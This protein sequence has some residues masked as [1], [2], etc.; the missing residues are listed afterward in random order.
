MLKAHAGIVIK[1]A[2]CTECH[3]PHGAEKPKLLLSRV[4]SPFDGGCDS[5]HD[6]PGTAGGV[7]LNSPEPKLCFTCHPDKEEAMKMKVVHKPYGAGKCT[8]CH[9]PHAARERAMLRLPAV[10][11]CKDCHPGVPDI[12][13]PV[14][15]HPAFK[16]GVLNPRD[17]A[18][19]FYC[20][21]CHDPHAGEKSGL[22]DETGMVFCQ[23]CHN[24][25]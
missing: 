11:L 20:A 5:C 9:S 8:R 12:N 3:D 24:Q 2:K 25:Q 17:T 15:R 14:Q 16:N 21:S 19:P 23:K 22:R 1:D 10:A 4:H 7:K 6:K 13:H 18:K